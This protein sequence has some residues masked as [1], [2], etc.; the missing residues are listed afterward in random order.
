MKEQFFKSR[1]PIMEAVMNGGSDLSLALAV[2]DAG[3]FP[4][5]W[6]Q[7]D[8]KLYK[9]I[10]EFIK[11]T[12][13]SN[14]VVGGISVQRV[15]NPKLVKILNHFKISHVEILANDHRTGNFMTMSNVLTDDKVI[16]AFDMLKKTSKLITRIYKPTSCTL[17]STYFDG[18]GIKG[19]ESAGKSGN[20]SVLELF[21]TQ[22][23]NSNN[24]LI[25]Y[26]GIGTPQQVKYYLDRG[27]AGV[28][29]G[30]LFAASQESSLSHAAK[31]QIITA[32][33]SSLTKLTDTNQNSLLL[34]NNFKTIAPTIGM[35][36]NRH[37]YL[38]QGLH[39]NGD[40]GLLY[41]G[42][43][44]DYVNEIK[45]VKDIIDYLVSELNY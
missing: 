42:E 28:A 26:G 7:N 31:Q 36:W 19:K 41:I 5:Y 32:N 14:I 13:H 45:P 9:D 38:E 18:Y 6:Y 24:C 25:P 12:G 1:Y 22:K 27:A 39:G 2:A 3:G 20:Y 40:E 43:G 11:C 15:S 17:S 44:V 30:T 35:D 34:N 16:T 37:N 10:T 33:S 4:S 29:V 21:E 23:C 8:E